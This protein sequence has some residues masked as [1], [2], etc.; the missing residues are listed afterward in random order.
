ME[1]GKLLSVSDR[2]VGLIFAAQPQVL[3]SPVS[4]FF[5]MKKFMSLRFPS[6][7]FLSGPAPPV[8]GPTDAPV[9]STTTPP[10][11][12]MRNPHNTIVRTQ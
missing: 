4:V 3:A 1:A 2:T 6:V 9:P 10:L 7:G 5:L 8:N 11:P 12:V